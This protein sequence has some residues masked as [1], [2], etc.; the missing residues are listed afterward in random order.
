[1]S[2]VTPIRERGARALLAV[3]CVLPIALLSMPSPW[4]GFGLAALPAA[5]AAGWLFTPTRWNKGAEYVVWSFVWGVTVAAFIV[6][7]FMAWTFGSAVTGRVPAP[8]TPLGYAL[9][10]VIVAGTLVP[11]L[12]LP[13]AVAGGVWAYLARRLGRRGSRSPSR[14]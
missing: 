8:E 11:I 6:V 9:M 12:T 3:L 5:L 2:D 14:I 1:M 7:V 4:W 10:L 13:Y